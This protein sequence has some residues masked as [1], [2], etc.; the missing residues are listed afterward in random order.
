MYL[1]KDENEK[2]IAEATK[3]I[4]LNPREDGHYVLRAYCHINAGN[5]HLALADADRGVNRG[6]V[7]ADAAE[8]RASMIQKTIDGTQIM[9]SDT[10]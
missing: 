1:F 9:R 7:P 3:A 10:P 6:V 5:L 4:R 2:A 8:V